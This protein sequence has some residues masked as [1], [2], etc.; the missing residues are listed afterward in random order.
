[1]IELNNIHFSRGDKQILQGVSLQVPEHQLTVILGPNGAGKS[2]LL[3]VLSGQLKP[4]DGEILWDGIKNPS[5]NAN[6][7]AQRRT[8][9]SQKIQLNFSIQIQQLIEM[10]CYAA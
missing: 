8:V 10:G 3:E 7:L 6:T 2:T 4:N 9:M 1:M 5:W